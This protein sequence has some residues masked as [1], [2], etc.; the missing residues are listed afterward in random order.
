MKHALTS[1]AVIFFMCVA[2]APANAGDFDLPSER[3]KLREWLADKHADLG[4]EY[5]K[6]LIFTIARKQYD[7]ARELEPDNRKAWQGL[8]YKKKGDN[9]VLDEALPE[10]DGVSGR[11]YLEAIKKPDEEKAKTWEKCADR[12]RKLMDKAAKAGDA[13]AARILAIDLLYYLP[14]DPEARKLRGHSLHEEAWRPD[15]VKAWR[16]EG[17]NIHEG[18]GF[19]DELE[20]EDEQAKLIGATFARRKSEWLITRT[21][22]DVTRA[23]LLHR[24]ALATIKRATELLAIDKPPFGG[25]QYTITHLQTQPEYESMLTKVLQL[26]GSDLEFAKRLAGHGQSKPY[27]YFCWSNS[28]TGANDMLCNTIALRV[29]AH[30]QDGKSDRAPWIDT[31][32]GYFVTS[33]VLNTTHTRRYTLEQAG[34]TASDH[35]II[36]EF[37]KKSGSPEL[38]REVALY[39]ISFDRDVPMRELIATKIND[40]Q[41]S[42]AAKSFSFM[43]FAFANHKEAAQKWLKSGG[44]QEAKDR[45]AA[46]ETAFGKSLEELENEWREWVLLNY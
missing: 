7:R 18:E 8:G 4:D 12:C 3:A 11:E 36:P 21:T 25:H 10:E 22:Y 28:D 35:E 42:H 29:L 14:D 31:G 1:F 30:H 19:G 6:V 41:Q 43:E 24:A 26:E 23:K 16:E 40:M 38:L 32:W 33:H 44:Q 20:G 39:N 46:I 13:R 2:Y 9:W 37:T 5:A 34:A 45:V 27:G 15:F 17:K